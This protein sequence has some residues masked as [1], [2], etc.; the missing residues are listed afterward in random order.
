MGPLSIFCLSIFYVYGNETMFDIY[1]KSYVVCLQR[2]PLWCTHILQVSR[3]ISVYMGNFFFYEF[4]C[5]M[6]VFIW[7]T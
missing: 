7:F 3:V 4:E 5:T 2:V 6:Q 1:L